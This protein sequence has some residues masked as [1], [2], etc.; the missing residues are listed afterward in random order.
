MPNELQYTGMNGSIVDAELRDKLQTAYLKATPVCVYADGLDVMDD[1][2]GLYGYERFLQTINSNRSED[3][4]EKEDMLV[5]ARSMGWT[6]RMKKP[7]MML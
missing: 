5:W 4:E 2:G 7:E 6:G 1:V 3:E